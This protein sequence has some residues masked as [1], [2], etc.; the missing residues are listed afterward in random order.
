MKFRNRTEKTCTICRRL[1]PISDF[2]KVKSRF[3]GHS[4]N[5]KPCERIRDIKKY[6]SKKCSERYKLIKRASSRKWA[7]KNKIKA[8]AHQA[9]QRALRLGKLFKPKNCSKCNSFSK[10][11]GHHPDYR[12]PLKV[13]W[14]CVSCH[15]KEHHG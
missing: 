11:H 2:H 8:Y 3:D 10:L 15:E 7:M 13:V 12:K 9:V 6:N 14:L 1:K 5:C 4:Y